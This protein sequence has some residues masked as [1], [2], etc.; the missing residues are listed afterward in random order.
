MAN[1]DF[2]S[3]CFFDCDDGSTTVA[4]TVACFQAQKYFELGV[5]SGKYSPIC[6][7]FDQSLYSDKQ[8]HPELGT[9]TCVDSNTGFALEPRREYSMKYKDV[10]ICS[11]TNC[12]KE[13][14]EAMRLIKERP[15]MPDLPFVPLC[16]GRGLYKVQ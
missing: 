4:P 14:G 16:D 6:D 13:A 7:P 8:C 2:R 5:Y 11:Q 1:I 9:C 10:L 15:D 3:D 12:I